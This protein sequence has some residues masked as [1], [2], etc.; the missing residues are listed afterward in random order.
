MR[1][2]TV[3]V[4]AAQLRRLSATASNPSSYLLRS[5]E[6]IRRLKDISVLLGTY[7]SFIACMYVRR[8]RYVP[9]RRL[10]GNS[11]AKL[12]F[13]HKSR[14]RAQRYEL[15]FSSLALQCASLGSPSS[16][17]HPEILKAADVE[18]LKLR[19]FRNLYISG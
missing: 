3:A 19:S 16:V 10:R 2:S 18:R 5:M 8:S 12:Q 15:L 1:D 14:M 13:R 9:R 11:L 6:Q 4:A 17:I 7:I